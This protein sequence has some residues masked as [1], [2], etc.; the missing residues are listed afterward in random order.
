VA[1]PPPPELLEQLGI[2]PS[3]PPHPDCGCP[4]ECCDGYGPCHDITRVSN[5]RDTPS[6]R[7]GPRHQANLD[8]SSTSGSFELPS[9]TKGAPA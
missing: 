3:S 7:F 9:H 2:D 6:A 4:Y 8:L 5:A 1:Q